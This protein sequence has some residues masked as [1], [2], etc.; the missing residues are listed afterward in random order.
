MFKP[1]ELNLVSKREMPV[2]K[3]VKSVIGVPKEPLLDKFEPVQGGFLKKWR[4]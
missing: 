4:F 3:R 1:D 2:S